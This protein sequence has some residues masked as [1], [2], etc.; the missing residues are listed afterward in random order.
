MKKTLILNSGS[1]SNQLLTAILILLP[2]RMLAQCTTTPCDD[3]SSLATITAASASILAA[4]DN[5][6][7]LGADTSSWRNIYVGTATY[8]GQQTTT[9]VIYYND[10]WFIHTVGGMNQSFYAGEYAGRNAKQTAEVNNGCV[11]VGYQALNAL[12]TGYDVISPSNQGVG[13]HN[14]AIGWRSLINANGV[15]MG[16]NADKNTMVG[17]RAGELIYNGRENTGIGWNVFYRTGASNSITGTGNVGIG[18]ASNPSGNNFNGVLGWLSSGSFNTVVGHGSGTLVNTGSGNTI[19]GQSA[20]T[21]LE[22]GDDNVF[23]GS[24]SGIGIVDGDSNII[25]GNGA[26]HTANIS[27]YLNIGGSIFGNL[28]QSKISIGNNSG[29]LSSM[30]N[31]GSED[32]FQVSSAGSVVQYN[33]IATVSNGVPAA[34]AVYD[35]TGQT[36]SIGATTVYAVPAG[37][38]GLYRISY[39][40]K[41]TATTA[42]ASVLNLQIRYTDADDTVVT[43]MPATNNNGVN[44]I[45]ANSTT[46][47]MVGSCFVVNAA[48]SS[49]IQLLVNH[50]DSGGTMTYAVHV[51]VEKL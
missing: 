46:T 20:G 5:A 48:E 12:G 24:T 33:D 4:T 8:F 23:L 45:Q 17:S 43:T 34:Y 1:F 15:S 11:G 40:L 2:F 35:A 29:T 19:L 49:N 27:H 14:T 9:P 31:V 10:N 25:I 28:S 3:L 16:T 13:N 44:Q 41:I 47:G 26:G 22:D 32:Q 37:A 51:I 42:T 38:S 36:A 7:D 30:F 50:A 18:G 39:T 21:S 6:L